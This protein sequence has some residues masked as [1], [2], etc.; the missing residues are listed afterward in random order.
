MSSET[1]DVVV[2][3]VGS[4]GQQ[5]AQVARAGRTVACVE[6]HRVGGEC[7][8]VACMPS[9]ALL[10]SAQVRHLVATAPAAGAARGTVELEA[11]ERAYAT[12]VARRN[13]IAEHRDDAAHA[14]ELTEAG[15]R[16]YGAGA[17]SSVPAPSP[18]A[19]AK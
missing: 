3:G 9:K 19:S 14:R 4:A 13:S 2:L 18:W 17:A 5:I 15:P 16:W 10:R 1:Y 12:A 7:P 11:G 6:D 8:F